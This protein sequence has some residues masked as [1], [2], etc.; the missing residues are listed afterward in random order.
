MLHSPKLLP[1]TLTVRSGYEAA[2][3]AG[4]DEEVATALDAAADRARLR[5]AQAR[6]GTRADL[7]QQES[8]IARLARDGLS[9][10]EIGASLFITGH[11]VEYHL[12]KVFAK[13]GVNSRTKLATALPSD[14]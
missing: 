12:R 6:S 11:T 2:A 10:A 14:T 5:G 1:K 4:A 13:L 7:A 9:N 3:A 8:Q